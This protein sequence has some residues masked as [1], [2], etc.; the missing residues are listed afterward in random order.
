M[1]YFIECIVDGFDWCGVYY[2]CDPTLCI[3]VGTESE[4]ENYVELH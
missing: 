2:H 3:F 1:K 4:C